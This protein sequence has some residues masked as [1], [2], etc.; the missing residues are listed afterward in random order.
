MRT[1]NRSLTS[2]VQLRCGTIINLPW[3]TTTASLTQT[4]YQRQEPIRRRPSRRVGELL[5]FVIGVVGSIRGCLFVPS[6][7]LYTRFARLA[8]MEGTPLCAIPRTSL[9]RT[10]WMRLHFGGLVLNL[11]VTYRVMGI[12]LRTATCIRTRGISPMRTEIFW[13]GIR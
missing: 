11:P 7:A 3:H 4:S 8:T 1:E 6:P 2:F 10:W 9:R 13:S 5:P 12:R